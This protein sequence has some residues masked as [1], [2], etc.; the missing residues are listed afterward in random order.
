MSGAA[1]PAQVGS[2]WILAGGWMVFMALVVFDT[3]TLLKLQASVN[4]EYHCSE[5][6]LSSWMKTQVQQLLLLSCASRALFDI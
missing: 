2:G 4:G 3:D 5:L 1:D 6:Y